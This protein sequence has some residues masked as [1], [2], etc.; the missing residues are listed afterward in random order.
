MFTECGKIETDSLDI[1]YK[2]IRKK[3]KNIN[4]KVESNGSLLISASPYVE[5][6]FIRKM[7][8]K[9][10]AFIKKALLTNANQKHIGLDENNLFSGGEI[11]F[12]G[13][14]LILK[15]EEGK[16]AAFF[17]ENN[18]LHIY[19]NSQNHMK[20]RKK[21]LEKFLDGRLADILQRLCDEAF[22]NHCFIPQFC[23]N[24]LL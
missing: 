9:N 23:I 15:F 13:N 19:E 24:K 4:F 22:K 11:Y 7:I 18:I 17:H 20:V 3:V 14:K 12:L 16:E 21:S 10:S 1:E 6:A 5:E 2:I 8:L